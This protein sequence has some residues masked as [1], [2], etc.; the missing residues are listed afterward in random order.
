MQGMKQPEGQLVITE[1]PPS[2]RNCSG[3]S[4]NRD[5][6][7][8]PSMNFNNINGFGNSKSPSGWHLQQSGHSI[9]SRDSSLSNSHTV[10]GTNQGLRSPPPSQFQE[11][12]LMPLQEISQNTNFEREN[13]QLVSPNEPYQHRP[14]GGAGPMQF[15]QQ[16]GAECMGK[17]MLAAASAPTSWVGGMTTA[18]T[19]K[20]FQRSALEVSRNPLCPST[21][22]APLLT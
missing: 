4:S 1:L 22:N 13:R 21:A 14:P 8:M 17:D 7:Q 15:L 19:F 11:R 9:I 12:A 20:H 18:E 2:P 6:T 10:Q 5:G 3:L 16:M